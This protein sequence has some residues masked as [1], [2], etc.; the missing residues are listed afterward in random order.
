MTF[1][2]I[3]TC[4]FHNIGDESGLAWRMWR[5]LRNLQ[6]DPT[7]SEDKLI[8]LHSASGQF[9][10]QSTVS[11]HH[12]N[13]KKSRHAWL[14]WSAFLPSKVSLFLWRL[15]WNGLAVDYNVQSKSIALVSKCNF[16]L[17]CQIEMLEHL[18]F[19]SDLATFLCR[20]FGNLLQVVV[21]HDLVFSISGWFEAAS[22]TSY[23]STL[24]GSLSGFLCWH[25][26]R[27]HCSR[28]FSSR[29][30]SDM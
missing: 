28:R 24:I 4:F 3:V 25:I 1:S 15:S 5:D 9:S 2:I 20:F 7:G 19:Q 18:F 12:L 10:I 21:L 27:E 16:C 30:H 29:T 11:K 23:R 14:I 26:W 13:Y 17:Q 6:G 22:L 8:W